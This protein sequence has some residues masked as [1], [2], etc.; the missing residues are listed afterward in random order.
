MNVTKDCKQIYLGNQEIKK[1][2]AGKD[3]V[4]EKD[5]WKNLE[6]MVVFEK[7]GYVSFELAQIVKDALDEEPSLKT[8]YTSIRKDFYPY[9]GKPINRIEFHSRDRKMDNKSKEFFTKYQGM[10][11]SFTVTKNAPQS[12]FDVDAAKCSLIYSNMEQTHIFLE[13]NER[14]FEPFDKQSHSNIIDSLPVENYYKNNLFLYHNTVSMTIDIEK[15][16]GYQK[17]Y[18]ENF[19]KLCREAELRLFIFFEM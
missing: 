12:T 4:W 2:F 3:L 8:S 13:D 18:W 11:I 14:Y 10:K 6:P 7:D 1:V 9:I 5:P 19:Y 15:T 16:D 17:P